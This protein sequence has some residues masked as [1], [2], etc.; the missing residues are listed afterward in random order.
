MTE[1][2]EFHVNQ[3]MKDEEEEEEGDYQL[4]EGD[5]SSDRSKLTLEK[6]PA[7]SGNI[8]L[9]HGNIIIDSRKEKH[10][11]EADE[12]LSQH[13]KIYN[14]NNNDHLGASSRRIIIVDDF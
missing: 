5:E 8:I 13:S 11:E 6:S 3:Q 14:D 1:K 2:D 7:S 9:G 10:D 4:K 12:V